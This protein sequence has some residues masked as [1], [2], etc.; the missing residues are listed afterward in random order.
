MANMPI[1]RL[2]PRF[3]THRQEPSPPPEIEGDTWTALMVAAQAGHG[4]AYQ[5][6]LCES[7]LWLKHYFS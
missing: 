4:G 5:R 1:P 2:I 3:R 7:A 6:L